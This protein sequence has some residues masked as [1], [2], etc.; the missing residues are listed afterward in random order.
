M[1]ACTTDAT[2]RTTMHRIRRVSRR[3]TVALLLLAGSILAPGTVA[4][5]TP[6]DG[7]VRVRIE[8][9][10]CDAS[11]VRVRIRDGGPGVAAELRERIFQPFFTT[12]PGGTGLGLALA[13]RTA[14]EHGGSLTL[15][16]DAPEDGDGAARGAE[17][18]LELPS[19]SSA[20]TGRS[21]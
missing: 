7:V 21:S 1:S 6:A 5:A 15:A 2:W 13:Q 12:K 3:V 17:F 14:E 19:A 18:V 11:P 16:G 20:L 10:R 9:A 4:Q 8:R